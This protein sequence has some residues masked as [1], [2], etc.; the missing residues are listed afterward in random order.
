MYKIFLLLIN[1]DIKN[2]INAYPKLE[3]IFF[4]SFK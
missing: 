3:L 1:N 4:L 2:K